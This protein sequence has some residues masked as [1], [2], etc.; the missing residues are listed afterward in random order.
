MASK[1]AG[2][3]AEFALLLEGTG[4]ALHGFAEYRDP[5]EGE[6]SY[7][8][9]AALKARALHDQLRERGISAAVLA[10]DSGLEVR[11]LGG[12]PG[13]V[14]ATYGGEGLSWAQRRDVLRSALD[15]CATADR[16]ARF[17]CALHYIGADDR[18]IATFATVGGAIATE[19]RGDLGFS[20]DPIFEYVPMRKTFS[21]MSAAEKNAISHRAVAFAALVAGLRAANAS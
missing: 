12:A 7:F 17:V 21:E 3:R 5:I 8:D 4:I 19:D 15:A 16:A 13:V 2:K 18:E 11:A 1:N 9:N 6:T 14:T 10:D 20:F